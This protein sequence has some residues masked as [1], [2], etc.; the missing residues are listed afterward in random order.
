[1]K[2]LSFT[3]DGIKLYENQSLTVDF[4]ADK[5]VG[6]DEVG[7]RVSLIDNSIYTLNTLSFVGINASGKTTTLNVIAGIL[8]IY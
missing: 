6:R 2:V 1:M 7:T 5:R 8:D 3:I 4:Y